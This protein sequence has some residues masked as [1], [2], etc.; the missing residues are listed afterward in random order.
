MDANISEIRAIADKLLAHLLESGHNVVSLPH[1]YYWS[2][3]KDARY[4]PYSRPSELTLGQISDDLNELKRIH[5]GETDPLSYA[6]VWLASVL[7]AIGEET[8]I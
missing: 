3:P 7:R 4:N 1:D 6:L 2:I 8:V 5:R